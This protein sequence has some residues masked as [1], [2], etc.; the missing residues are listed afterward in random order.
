MK[1]G[2]Y[3]WFP[4]PVAFRN[5]FCLRCNAATLSRAI[6]TV[7]FIHVY[8]IPLIP[9]GFW[10][11][12]FCVEC[13]HAPSSP[14]RTRKVFKWIGV[15]LLASMAATFWFWPLEEDPEASLAMVWT[16]RV[17]PLVLIPLV[18]WS[19]FRTPPDTS[20]RRERK[21]VEPHTDP[22]CPFC[23]HALRLRK[24]WRCDTCNIERR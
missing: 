17:V 7:D 15:F 4:K 24:N 9:I 21:A 14:V 23:G 10:R 8:W 1:I 2:R 6:R 3:R 18:I 16:Y 19:I 20:Y 12:W 13:N 22:T 11:R 5:D